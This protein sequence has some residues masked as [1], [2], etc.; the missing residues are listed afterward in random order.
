MQRLSNLRLIWA[1]IVFCMLAEV[2]IGPATVCAQR[3]SEV[4]L[5][6][7]KSTHLKYDILVGMLDVLSG[8]A[9][10]E[11]AAEMVMDILRQDLKYSNLFRVGASLA[12]AETDSLQYQ[13]VVEGKV[14]GPLRDAE[15]TGEELPTTISFN[16]LTYPERQLVLNKRYRPLPSQLRPSAHHFANQVV[17]YLTGEKGI[18]LTRIVFS[19]GNLDRRDLYVI[20]YDGENLLR[21]TANRT[22]NLCPAWKPDGS[23]IAFTSYTQGLQ[24]VYSLEIHTGKVRNIIA[25]A[26]LNIGADWDPSGAEIVLSLS[27]S[28]NPEIYRISPEGRV[29]RRLTV[30][31]A[32]EISPDWSPNGQDVVFTS[33][34]TGTPQLYIMDSDGAGRHRLTFEGRYNDSAAW[35]PN[36]EKLI[37][38]CREGNYTQLVLINTNGTERRVLT[39]RHWRNAEDPSWA[40][41]GR[42]VVFASDRTGTF[43]LYILDVVEDTHRQLTF[44]DLPDITPAWSP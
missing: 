22:L 28:G 14:E 41:D 23:E 15:T 8:G 20:D 31:P 1:T 2:A 7:T 3:V 42:H 6:V 33:D 25:T 36:G 9:K 35:S 43:N 12:A 37:Y 40:P 21:M 30:S 34:R 32:I 24:G 11:L 19:R 26:G 5:G 38:A 4:E 13:F 39:N 18:A 10:S 44:G 29:K 16:L 27:K 17:E